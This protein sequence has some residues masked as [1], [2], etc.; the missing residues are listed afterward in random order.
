MAR[1]RFEID[2]NLDEIASAAPGGEVDAW[3]EL[4]TAAAR[5]SGRLRRCRDEDDLVGAVRHFASLLR[6]GVATL[7]DWRDEFLEV[8]IEL[9][10]A[11]RQ[12]SSV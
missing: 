3:P 8:L 6:A 9:F 7:G 10:V 5:L 11:G 2:A 4:M 12:Q 1:G